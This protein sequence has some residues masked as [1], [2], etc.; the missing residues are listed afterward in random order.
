VKVN[1][2]RGDQA[3]DALAGLAEGGKDVLVDVGNKL[4]DVVTDPVGSFEQAADPYLGVVEDVIP[5]F[6]IPNV[7][8]G[9]IFGDVLTD[10]V[11]SGKTAGETL[12]DTGKTIGDVITDPVGSGKTAGETLV[13]TGKTIGNVL[14][15]FKW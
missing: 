10:P 1:R 6:K 7:P 4:T 11:G 15:P 8:G 9:S 2:S 3:T 13:D 14:N 12:V 5:G